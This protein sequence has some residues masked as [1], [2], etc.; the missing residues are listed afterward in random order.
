MTE[1]SWV[2][3]SIAPARLDIRRPLLI[4]L[5]LHRL[6][7]SFIIVSQRT[8]T[9]TGCLLGAN[10]TGNQSRAGRYGWR[11]H[12]GWLGSE[13]QPQPAGERDASADPDGDG[14]TNLREYQ[15]GTD[16]FDYFNGAT[17]NLNIV[18]GDHQLGPAGM[19]LTQSLVIQ[20]TN[21]S[22]EVTC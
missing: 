5:L 16:P 10:A 17:F 1:L 21:G 18:T 15:N 20:T 13:S 7:I 22:G 14:F 8:L 12:P 11:R 19:W 2:V 4:R 6:A 9:A 3:A